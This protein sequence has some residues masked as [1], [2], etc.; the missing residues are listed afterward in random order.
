MPTLTNIGDFAV[1]TTK[2][3]IP[4]VTA[5]TG[6]TEQ[7]S[8]NPMAIIKREYRYSFTNKVKSVWVEIVGGVL[9]GALLDPNEELFVDFRYTLIANGPTTVDWVKPQ[10]TQDPIAK[11]KFLGFEPVM[12]CCEGGNITALTKIENFTF[13]PYKVNPAVNMYRDL[14]YTINTL[15]GHDVHY[16]RAMPLANGKDFTLK[17]WTLYDVDEPQCFKLL[18]PNNEFPDNKIN[19]GP[20]GLDFEM[21][22]EVH[23]VK[24]YFE[25]IFGVGTGPQKRD[26]VYFPLTNR[27][28]EVGSSYLYRDFMQ[29]DSYWKVGLVKYAPRSN[30]YETTDLRESLDEISWDAEERF[31][32]EIRNDEVKK[33]K[34]QQYN[35]KIGSSVDPVRVYLDDKLN[36]TQSDLI[37]YHTVLSRSQYDLRSIYDST[38]LNKIAVRYTNPSIFPSSENRAF[39]AWFKDLQPKTR[40]PKDVI[41]NIMQLGS[42]YSD[43]SLKTD[44]VNYAITLNVQR[45]YQVGDLIKITRFNGFSVFGYWLS[46][47]GNVH[48]IRIPADILNNV[49]ALYPN[50]TSQ[51][52]NYAELSQEKVLFSGYNNTTYTGWEFSVV[53]KRFFI[54]KS[55]DIRYYFTMQSDLSDTEW[56]GVFLNVSNTYGQLT[57]D[58]WKRRW[59]ENS[60]TPD[61]TTDLEKIYTKTQTITGDDRDWVNIPIQFTANYDLGNDAIN[62]VQPWPAGLE[63]GQ[64]VIG[65]GIPGDSF[66]TYINETDSII[67]ITKPPIITLDGMDLSSV[68]IEN[69][70]YIKPSEMLLT[71]IRLYKE[72]EPDDIKQMFI[73]NQNIVQD[74]HLAIVIDNALP[75]LHLPFIAQTK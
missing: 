62:V 72:N 55:N 2:D 3:P 73:L 58:V 9:S 31:G 53:A 71:N 19:F 17:E 32:E 11:D 20:Y 13:D 41:F 47:I 45:V 48:T 61:Q 49:N 54:F 68:E 43:S 30:R 46:S 28:Y 56:Y 10:Y 66:I 70:Y 1:F 69:R 64:L 18:V 12:I 21:P 29:K 51:A 16:A 59:D 24:Q 26:I 57:V 52:S 63:I 39:S 74:S 34:P 6:Y 8:G 42:V 35:Q 25:D 27:I 22:F 15:F 7:I 4:Y 36:I 65:A 33:V 60:T 23:V 75:R 44:V 5:L 14:S 50:W 38:D 40:V 37:N 67:K